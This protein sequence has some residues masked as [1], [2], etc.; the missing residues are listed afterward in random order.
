MK[1]TP[2]K[3]A[4]ALGFIASMS[5]FNVANAASLV[6]INSA[7]QI[8]VFDSANV[9]AATFTNISG[10]ASGDSLIGIDLRPTN[11]T[12]YGVSSLNNIY[13]LNATSG[14]ATLV[15]SLSGYSIDSTLGYGIDFNPVADFGGGASLRLVS[16]AG[17]NLA[18][19]V[20][21]GVVGN[22][23]AAGRI[24]EGFSAVAYANSTPGQAPG[25]AGTRLYYLNSNTDTLHLAPGNFNM[26]TIGQVGSGL[27]FDIISANGFDLF[28]DSFA[29]AAV[30]I[31]GSATGKTQFLG[32]DLISGAGT[33][34]G[35]FNG[36]LNGLTAAPSAVPVPAAAWLFGSALLGLAGIR[37]KS[38]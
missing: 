30:N 17:D 22:N 5:V 12:I 4:L 14:A 27:G 21:T 6:G 26:P 31:L 2:S 20:N 3:I 37:R 25:A 13:T 19:N 34:L 18:V 33:L 36:T 28:S 23:V 9:G 16:S 15:A 38:V 24:A 11:N 32:I 35:E 8:G 10:L 1:I 7:N 29:F